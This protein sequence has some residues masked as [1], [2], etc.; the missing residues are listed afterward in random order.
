M[1]G[2]AL[3]QSDGKIFE[4]A[5]FLEQNVEV[6]WLFAYWYKFKK[7][8]IQHILI[9]CGQHGRKTQDSRISVVTW[10]ERFQNGLPCQNEL[11]D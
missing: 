2:N 7:K 9:W 4:S 1:E 3:G 5:M 10:V 6:A 11:M 8:M